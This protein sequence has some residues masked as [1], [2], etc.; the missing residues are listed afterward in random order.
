L[1]SAPN[2][3]SKRRASI[4]VASRISGPPLALTVARHFSEVVYGDIGTARRL[5]FTVIGRA[6]NEASRLEVL[7]QMV[8]CSLLMSEGFARR[9]GAGA[10]GR[11]ISLARHAVR[12][13]EICAP[14]GDEPGYG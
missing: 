3:S 2:A 5:D 7:C 9:L 14:A 4:S 1:Y 8:G 13:R 12:E 11:V 10:A 6:V